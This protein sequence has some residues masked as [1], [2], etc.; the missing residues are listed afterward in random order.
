MNSFGRG[1]ANLLKNAVNGSFTLANFVSETVSKSDMKQYLP[2]PPWVTQQKIETIL[3]L[4]RVAQ[5]GQGKNIEC[6]IMGVIVC[7]ITKVNLA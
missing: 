4:C 6:D 2:W 7:D 3:Y 5:G 1:H